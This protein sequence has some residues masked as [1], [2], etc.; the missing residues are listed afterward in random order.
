M[1]RRTPSRSAP[2]RGAADPVREFFRHLRDERQ[3]SPHTLAA[4]RVDLRQFTA[5]LDRYYGGDWRWDRVDRLA[6]RAF[7]GD[8]LDRA[9]TRRTVARKLSAVRSLY[10]FL[11]R[12]GRVA[13]NPAR[14]VRAPRQGRRLPGVLSLSQV[15]RLF[16][17]VED[18][19]DDSF[20]YL[21]DRALLE[22]LYSSGLRVSEAQGLEWADVDAVAGQLRVR[23]KGRKERL[24]PIGRTA[25]AALRE[26][27]RARRRVRRPLDGAPVFVSET[28][29]RLSVRQIRRIVKQWIAA[30]ADPAGLSTHA[31]RHSFATHLLDHGADLM[32]VKELLGHA[33]LSTTRIYT[34]TTR[35]RL[36]RV[37]R[38][39]HPRA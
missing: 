34:H 28:G 36:G 17:R 31:L 19:A 12:E 22:V 15:E 13:L 26:Y 38:R 37:Y 14:A 30:V 4:Y 5:F 2:R 3:L 16:H 24:V 21:R 39:A 20:R 29:S 35:E 8:S 9:W 27:E 11:H 7:V 18:A 25:L 23:G 33:S 1:S 10:R 6:L 32:A